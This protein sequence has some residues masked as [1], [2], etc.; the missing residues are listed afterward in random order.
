MYDNYLYTPF[1]WAGDEA[2]GWQGMD[3]RKLDIVRDLRE[4]DFLLG[5]DHEV[6][7]LQY[8]FLSVIAMRL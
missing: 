2:K 8:V 3:V 6:M 4:Q 7:T 5:N 1:V